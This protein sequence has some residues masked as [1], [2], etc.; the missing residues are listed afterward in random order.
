MAHSPHTQNGMYSQLGDAQL[1]SLV[2]ALESSYA[3]A[4][5][6]NAH[7]PLRMSLWKAGVRLALDPYNSGLADIVHVLRTGFM[8]QLPNLLKQETTALHACLA[9]LF[10]M[11]EDGARQDSW[12]EVESR[13]F[14]L[15]Y[16]KRSNGCRGLACLTCVL[17][18]ALQ[19]GAIATVQ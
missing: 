12:P 4:H 18:P 3:F 7:T 15:R 5:K 2:D 19:R 11:Y 10:R 16:G 13:L 14:R 1:L 6:F 9:L 8:R 17:A